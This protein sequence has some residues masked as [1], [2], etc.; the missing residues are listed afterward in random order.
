MTIEIKVPQLPES[1]ADATLVAWHRKAGDAVSRDENLAD[2]ET[3]KVVLEVPAPANGVLKEILIQA[4][5]TVRSGDLLA[6]VEPGAAGAAATP[7][8]K[9]PAAKAPAAPAAAPSGGEAAKL[10]P[11][12]KRLVEE[13][14]LDPGQIAGSGRD[15]RLTKGDV[16]GHLGK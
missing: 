3:D 14:K 1:V 13:N 10:S 12:V 15:G 11:A 9:P 8:A 6:T 7:A 2:L 4:G 16:V 5:A